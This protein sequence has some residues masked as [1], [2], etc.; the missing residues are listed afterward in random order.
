MACFFF[1]IEMTISQIVRYLENRNSSSVSYKTFNASPRDRY[2]AVSICFR[3]KWFTWYHNEEMFESIGVTP[4]AYMDILK[5]QNGARYEYLYGSGLFSKVPL[6]FDNMSSNPIGNFH[7]KQSDIFAS[8]EL[9]AKR[10]EDSMYY[11]KN[12]DN[13]FSE[14]FG[15]GLLTPDTICFTRNSNE[16]QGMLRSKDILAIK[17]NADFT[18]ADSSFND[19]EMSIHLHYP[20]QLWRSLEN[21]QFRSELNYIDFKRILELK[22]SNAVVERSRPDSNI[23]C[24][25]E[26][27]DDDKYLLHQIV[28]RVGC[29][30]PYWKNYFND[31]NRIVDCKTSEELAKLSEHIENYE[32]VLYSYAPPCVDMTVQAVSNK[33]RGN[34]RDNETLVIFSYMERFYQ[35]ISNTQDFSFESFWSTV[36]GFIGIFLGYPL[37]QLPDLLSFIVSLFKNCSCPIKKLF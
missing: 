34:P 24:N 28:E 13:R 6:N 33:D 15:I 8:I 3:G 36:G 19:V 7:L 26:I 35:E 23:P 31:T 9:R 29:V 25:N 12:E 10:F 37:L 22:I 32:G 2:P 14:L 21:P 20:G 5:G 18:I 30:P 17:Q 1:A 11:G 27:D 4:D 16:Q